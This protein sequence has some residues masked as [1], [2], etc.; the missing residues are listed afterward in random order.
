MLLT[1][2]P[3]FQKKGGA[4]FFGGGGRF[5]G[6]I[7]KG[8]RSGRDGRSPGG[9]LRD[10]LQFAG[11]GGTVCQCDRF[12]LDSPLP[13]PGGGLLLYVASP[14]ARLRVCLERESVRQ[15]RA[16]RSLGAAE[17]RCSLTSQASSAGCSPSSNFEF[18]PAWAQQPAAA[19][20]GLKRFACKFDR[21]AIGSP[22][23]PPGGGLQS[24]AAR[25]KLLRSAA[26]FYAKSIA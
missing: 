24:R 7:R 16:G 22:Q 11:F 14:S 17:A 20:D 21:T 23:P 8:A 19:D 6:R 25:C 3:F 1:V 10:S 12:A 18:A 13:S 4:A 26:G 5:A 2:P 15:D 9:H